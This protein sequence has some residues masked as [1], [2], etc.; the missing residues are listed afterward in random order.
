MHIL[1]DLSR[2]TTLDGLDH[3]GLLRRL[4]SVNVN[5]EGDEQN[6]VRR[7]DGATRVCCEH[8]TGTVTTDWQGSDPQVEVVED[9]LLVGSEINETEVQN[10]L[11][12]LETS[13]P[14]LPPNA[15]TSCSQEVVPVHNDVHTEVE[16]DRHPRNWGQT[17]QL[18]V[19]KKC[20]CTMVV[21]VQESQLLLLNDEENSVD[22]L[23]ELGEIVEVVK[24]DEFL[25][26]CTF[27]TDS[28]KQTVV[29]DDWNQLLDHQKEQ[30]QGKCSQ[31]QV[32]ELEQPIQNEWFNSELLKDEITAENDNI[33]HG[34]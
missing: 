34:N 28:I 21:S 6:E 11:D 4:L 29:V 19:T 9:D 33:V 20:G 18:G 5:V 1:V 23:T 14:F 31:E 7:Q 30:G 12:D 17:D 8:C 16:H 27:I 2:N 26:P 13:N 3:L 15:D 10:E 32:V 22:E 25:S 24:R